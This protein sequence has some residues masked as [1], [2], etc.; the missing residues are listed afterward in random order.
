MKLGISMLVIGLLFAGFGIFLW[1]FAG[2]AG[3]FT[4]SWFSTYEAAS[5]AKAIGMGVTIFGG[6]LAI[7]GIVR[8]IVKR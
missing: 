7:G 3:P 6:G 8:M 2:S 5:M 4:H 1:N